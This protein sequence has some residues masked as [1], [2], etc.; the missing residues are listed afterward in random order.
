MNAAM[1]EQNVI[2]YSPVPGFMSDIRG[3]EVTMT[4]KAANKRE[5]LLTKS[6]G[7][8]T[9]DFSE[10]IRAVEAITAPNES[11][12]ESV[13]AANGAT[14]TGV[15]VAKTIA[16]L[17]HAYSDEINAEVISKSFGSAPV[18]AVEAETITKSDLDVVPAAVRSKIE[19][20]IEENSVL[21]SRVDELASSFKDA[22]EAKRT[23]EFVAKAAS[24]DGL[25]ISA[26]ELGSVFKS[27]ADAAG[28]D[29]L[30]T[31]LSVL[32]SAN[33]IAKTGE[34]AILESHGTAAEGEAIDEVA[35]TEAM[36][37]EIAKSDDI[38]FSD[39]LLRVLKDNPGLEKAYRA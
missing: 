24:F 38:S 20:A 33:T 31:V 2:K 12:I 6:D 3:Y 35:K 13:A 11:E 8:F 18:E 34:G 26:E 1:N 23:N 5:Y 14:E 30:N 25:A 32:S 36:A 39:A 29:V 4:R 28:E 27:I 21:K 7:S 22:F 9:M 15:S 10:I 17:L 19:K 37:R 16:R